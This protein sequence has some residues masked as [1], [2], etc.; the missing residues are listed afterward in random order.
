MNSPNLNEATVKDIC[1]ELSRRS[2]NFVL[3]ANYYDARDEEQQPV[4]S[5]GVRKQDLTKAIGMLETA[6]V[7]L[8]QEFSQDNEIECPGEEDEDFDD[9][10]PF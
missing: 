7:Y 3:V 2:L 10:V 5:F 8:I 9:D 4:I 1:D 6:K